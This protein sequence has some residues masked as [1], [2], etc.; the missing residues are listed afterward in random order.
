MTDSGIAALNARISA[1]QSQF[2]APVAPAKGPSRAAG[3]ASTGASFAS[4]LDRA[5]ATSSITTDSAT[6]A[7]PTAQRVI[8]IAK[9]W[10]GTPY[11]Y[12]GNDPEKGI[13]CSGLVQQAFRRVG[14]ELPRVTYDQVKQ[15]TEVA[16][17]EEARPGD[18]IFKVGDRGQ[19]VNGH[20]GIYLGDGK[21][22]EAPY[23]GEKVRITDAPKEI[24]A[25][26][27]VIPNENV[28]TVIPS[29]AAA[30]GNSANGDLSTRELLTLL[31]PLMMNNSGLGSNAAVL[32]A[33]QTNAGGIA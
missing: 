18:L 33:L 11:V 16:S 26:R 32:S 9:E 29:A 4:A 20:V 2:I 5:L 30:P 14:I 3:S 17:I 8:D 23:T 22:I 6:G 1:I 21:W 25:I 12:G 13:D 15:G 19:R 10:I 24:T 27:R 28:S 31:L 7:S